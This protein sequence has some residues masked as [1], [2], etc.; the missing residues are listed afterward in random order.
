MAD[1]EVTP[2]DIINMWLNCRLMHVGATAAK[3]TFSR[4]DYERELARLGEAKFEYLFLT[5]CHR[6]GFQYIN[7]LQVTE[8]ILSTKWA[9]EGLKPSFVFDDDLAAHGAL[10]PQEWCSA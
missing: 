8:Q 3:G 7:L 5:A 1:P 9:S 10:R 6:V 2:E 4:D